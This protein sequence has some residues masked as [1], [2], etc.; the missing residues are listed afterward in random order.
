MI[1]Y[2]YFCGILNGSS[3][4]SPQFHHLWMFIALVISSP[5]LC[6]GC[7]NVSIRLIWLYLHMCFFISH[8]FHFSSTERWGQNTPH[9]LP[10][11]VP[12]HEQTVGHGFGGEAKSLHR[13]WAHDTHLVTMV[14]WSKLLF[15]VR[16]SSKSMWVF[17]LMLSPFCWESC[18][19]L[20]PSL[21]WAGRGLQS[22]Q[23]VCDPNNTWRIQEE[24]QIIKTQTCADRSFL[25]EPMMR[26]IWT[27]VLMLCMC[28][29]FTLLTH[30]LDRV[31]L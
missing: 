17:L 6:F 31:S 18:W 29:V 8:L 21:V 9:S 20:W 27:V 11:L 4:L 2:L 13:V 19:T 7:Q 14:A 28:W 1:I 16:R 25:L 26:C 23:Q 12:Q 30:R 22:P 24:S 5:V 15:A 3:A 10:A